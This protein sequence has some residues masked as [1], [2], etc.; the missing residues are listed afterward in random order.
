MGKIDQEYKVLNIEDISFY[1]ANPRVNDPAVPGVVG[2][3]R[4]YGFRGAVLVDENLVLLAG[5]TR[6]KSALE[7]GMS[8]VPAIIM[9]GMTEDQKKGFRIA[10]NKVA[11]GSD[12]DYLLLASEIEGLETF[13][14]FTD[15]ELQELF[16]DV[17]NMGDEF[18]LNDEDRSPFQQMSFV[19]S[20]DQAETIKTALIKAKKTGTYQSLETINENT[21]GNALFSIVSEW[22]EEVDG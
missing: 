6:L 5:D 8:S 19:L 15:E 14:G 3:I 1:S 13:T 10:D 16:P 12:W 17:E 9:S 2:S 20:D 11:E 18:S 21:N 4:E 22:L 7:L